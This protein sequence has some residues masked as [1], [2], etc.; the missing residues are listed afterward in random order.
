[1]IQ[2]CGFGRVIWLRENQRQ[3][4]KRHVIV[5]RIRPVALDGRVVFGET[6]GVN[7][8]FITA[9][10]KLGDDI[11]RKKASVAAGHVY[12]GVAKMQETIEHIFEVGH[13]LHFIEHDVI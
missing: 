12:I 5:P 2:I 7:S 13:E 3:A 1:M 6:Q 10:S 9:A 11:R 8:D 4:T